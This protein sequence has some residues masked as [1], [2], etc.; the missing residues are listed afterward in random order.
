[1][2]KTEAELSTLVADIINDYQHGHASQVEAHVSAAGIPDLNVCVDGLDSNIELKNCTKS[3]CPHVRASQYRWMKKRKAVRGK[4]CYMCHIPHDE[5][6][7]GFIYVVTGVDDLELQGRVT[8]EVW[9]KK[10]F[11]RWEVNEYLAGKLLNFLKQ[12]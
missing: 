12:Y 7:R 1:M 5:G 8:P 6:V 4:V 2:I 10:A 3:Y 11:T 9:K